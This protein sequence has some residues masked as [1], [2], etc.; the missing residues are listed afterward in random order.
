MQ[1]PPAWLIFKVVC[2]Y[3]C[4]C[5]IYFQEL[6]SKVASVCFVYILLMLLNSVQN[7]IRLFPSLEK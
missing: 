2:T 6:T 5:I 3:S 4:A 7:C 1:S